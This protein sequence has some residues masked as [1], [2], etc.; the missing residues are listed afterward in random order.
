MASVFF[1]LRILE[2]PPAA[3]NF[4]CI[5]DVNIAFAAE[6]GVHFT[7]G[8]GK[9][10]DFVVRE[11]VDFDGF[12]EGE[13]V[14]FGSVDFRF[15]HRENFGIVACGFRFRTFGVEAWGGGHIEAFVGTDAIGIVN[16]HEWGCSV[17]GGFN[18]GGSVCL[19]AENNVECGCAFI[20]CLFDER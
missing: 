17:A 7:F 10:D 2:C 9:H 11:F 12:G 20:L 18:A 13:S 6:R 5:V 14:E 8:Y 16:K 15:V 4:R 1:G 3:D 19:V